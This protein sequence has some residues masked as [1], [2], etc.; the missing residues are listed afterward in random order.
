MSGLIYLIGS[1]YEIVVAGKS[2]EA[3]GILKEINK[4]FIP[5][6]I[7]VFRPTEKDSSDILTIAK[8]VENYNDIDGKPTI[9]VCSNYKCNSPTTDIRT[10]IDLLNKK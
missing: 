2:S 5:N 9:Y 10:A 4:N 8:Y 7:I 6:K 3:V 1:S